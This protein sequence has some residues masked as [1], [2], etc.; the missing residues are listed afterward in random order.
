LVLPEDSSRSPRQPV[1]G[2]GS[3]AFL[4]DAP[5]HGAE[6]GIADGSPWPGQ[7][8]EIIRSV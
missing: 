6:C 7:W 3:G 5:T 8:A 1:T 2:C 4:T